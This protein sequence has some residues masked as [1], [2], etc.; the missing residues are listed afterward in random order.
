M[1][2]L[3]DPAV[4]L[5]GLF[6]CI[7]YDNDIKP[8]PPVPSR[9]TSRGD[10]I[11]SVQFKHFFCVFVLAFSTRKTF[12]NI[13][14]CWVK[15]GPSAKGAKTPILDWFCWG[16]LQVVSPSSLQR[17]KVKIPDTNISR[18]KHA[19]LVVDV[20]G[21]FVSSHKLPLWLL[22]QFTYDSDQCTIFF[23]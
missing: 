14:K 2:M 10:T 23:F 17:P 4:L 22:W 9:L 3:N 1:S 7:I 18:R 13:A 16:F 19:A 12:A 8:L 11:T 20:H 21:W 15:L 6:V 5:F